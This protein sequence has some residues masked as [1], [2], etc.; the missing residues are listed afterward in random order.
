M[1]LTAARERSATG[2]VSD[3]GTGAGA[4]T[5]KIISFIEAARRL[6]D[7]RRE[8]VILDEDEKFL[9]IARGNLAEY[10]IKTGRT[11]REA[12]HDMAEIGAISRR[13]PRYL[14]SLI[15][16]GDERDGP[17]A[18]EAG[19]RGGFRE[20][21][22]ALDT[23]TPDG[24]PRNLRP[25]VAAARKLAG[26]EATTPAQIAIL[27]DSLAESFGGDKRLTETA[28][29]FG[30]LAASATDQALEQKFREVRSRVQAPDFS[31]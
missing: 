8:M 31:R 29:A 9:V 12:A 26:S 15:G 11:S 30:V 22:A 23:A 14:G 16:R 28:I 27:A 21:L 18:T 20:T 1:K 2:K 4:P 7:P 6:G 10:V 17:L 5:G 24:I 25:R 13:D 3:P 19:V